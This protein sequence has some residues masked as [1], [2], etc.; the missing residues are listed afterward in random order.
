MYVWQKSN[1]YF[2]TSWQIVY[3]MEVQRKPN[4]NRQ[5]IHQDLKEIGRISVMEEG[6]PIWTSLLKK[7]EK[8]ILIWNDT[9]LG[10]KKWNKVKPILVLQLFQ[11]IVMVIRK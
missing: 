10:R 1:F 3:K 5:I 9:F 4:L 7:G 8:Y 11:R 2:L 6:K